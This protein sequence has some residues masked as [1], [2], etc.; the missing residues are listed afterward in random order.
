[1]VGGYF[2]A[3]HASWS[4]AEIDW[5]E[6]LI[7]EQDVDIMEVWSPWAAS[8]CPLNGKAQ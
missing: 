6:R 8:P 5:F 4:D 3:H 7:E 1:M 2:E